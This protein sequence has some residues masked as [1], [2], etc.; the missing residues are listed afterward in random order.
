MRNI[1]KVE[2]IMQKVNIEQGPVD[3][4]RIILG[5]MRMPALSVEDAAKMIED[6]LPRC[7]FASQTRSFV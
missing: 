5:C 1:I 2:G 7:S 6:G 3:A 4:S